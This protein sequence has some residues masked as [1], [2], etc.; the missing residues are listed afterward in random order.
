MGTKGPELVQSFV[1]L[2]T[3]VSGTMASPKREEVQS[4]PCC[5]STKLVM[6][7]VVCRYKL[8]PESTSLLSIVMSI[9][10]RGVVFWLYSK[11]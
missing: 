6:E 9:G 3:E 1:W 2:L 5:Q 11:F 4:C 8:R 7:L 10:I